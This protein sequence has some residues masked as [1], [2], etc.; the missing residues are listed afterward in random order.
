MAER[1]RAHFK[2]KLTLGEAEEHIVGRVI[3]L[4]L[5]QD[6]CVYLRQTIWNA[7]KQ[8]RK[9]LKATLLLRNCLKYLASRRNKHL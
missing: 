9:N 5:S 4:S 3:F 1:D 6:V 2:I 7:N 8:I